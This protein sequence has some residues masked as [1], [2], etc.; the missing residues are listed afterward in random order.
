MRELKTIKLA[1]DVIID[2]SGKIVLIKR[3]NPPYGWALPGGYVEYGES[4]EEAAIREI[5]EETGLDLKELKQFHVYSKPERDPRGH[6]VSVVFTAK[7]I[8]EPKASDDASE[9]GI[10]AIDNLPEPIAFDHLQILKD[11][12][13]KRYP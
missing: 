4:V 12:A 5:K 2:L 1:V 7:G 6:T 11:Y 10:F 9:I 3:K 13:Q 8:G